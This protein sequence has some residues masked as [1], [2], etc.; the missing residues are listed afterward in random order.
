MSNETF[1]TNNGN[2]PKLTEENYL[3]G[4]KRSAV[5][6]SPRKPTISSR[7]PNYSLSA[8]VSSYPFYKKAGMTKP[9][10]H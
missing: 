2:V 4:S 10:K 7:V 3:S 8:T 1:K 6:L 9:I 5:S